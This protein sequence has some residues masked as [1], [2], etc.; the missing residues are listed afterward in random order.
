MDT[1]LQSVSPSELFTLPEPGVDSAESIS[2]WQAA[3]PAR[4]RKRRDLGGAG[5]A[6]YRAGAETPR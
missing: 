1:A 3:P 6:W 2:A 5:H 4:I